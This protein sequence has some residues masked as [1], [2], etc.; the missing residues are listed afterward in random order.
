MMFELA[1]LNHVTRLPYK[2]VEAVRATYQ[3]Q[4][5]QEFL[6]LYYVPGSE[7]LQTDRAVAADSVF[8]QNSF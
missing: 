7:V 2:S 6:D 3:F 4:N 5:L 1:K 8:A